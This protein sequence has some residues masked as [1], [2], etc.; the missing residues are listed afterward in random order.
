MP[1]YLH[2][3]SKQYLRS[4][5]PASL[6][7]REA[8]YIMDPDLSVVRGFNSVYWIIT[9]DIVTLMSQTARDAVDTQVVS[10]NRDAKANQLDGLEDILRAF[11]LVV[12]DEFNVLRAQHG[13]A[14]R[15]IAQ[16]KSAIRG[17]LGS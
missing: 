13:L 6:P 15:T 5:S 7:E 12:L 4:F 1:D 11:A 10:D 8:N 16:L 17:K 2:R 9:G 14:A 3:V